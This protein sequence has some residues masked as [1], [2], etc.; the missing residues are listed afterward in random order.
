MRTIQY[1]F[2]KN[3]WKKMNKGS[4]ELGCHTCVPPNDRVFSICTFHGLEYSSWKKIYV[5]NSI[6]LVKFQQ[7][8]PHVVILFYGR[9][10]ANEIAFG[11][12]ARF[13]GEPQSTCTLASHEWASEFVH[14]YCCHTSCQCSYSSLI[15]I[16]QNLPYIVRF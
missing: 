5:K 2:Q 13:L 15:E 14:I 16:E 6:K 8:L 10:M 3:C 7:I 1:S 9:K 11:G 12:C 4:V